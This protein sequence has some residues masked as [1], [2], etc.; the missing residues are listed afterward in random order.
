MTPSDPSVPDE[1]PDPGAGWDRLAAG[2]QRDIGWPEDALTW[3]W[4]CPSEENLR[5]VCDDVAGA[6]TLVVGCGGGQD[7]VALA[8]YGPASLVGVDP[9]REQLRHARALLSERGLDAG[10]EVAR[11]EH[12]EGIADRSV[13]VAVSVQ[14]LNYVQD[15]EAAVAELRRV[16]RLDGVLAFSV[17]HPAEASTDDEPP[18]AWHTSWFTVARD[19][20]WDGMSDEPIAFRSWFHAPSAWFTALTDGGFEVER[21]LEPA[22]VEDPRWIDRGWLDDASYA[23]LDLVPATILVRARRR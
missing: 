18:Y 8:A 22:P 16:L 7:L 14:A 17:M 10:L 3:G 4:R 5:L 19:W 2:Y 21:L 23:K 12:L 6:D 11:A 15:L 9:S 13:D 1:R 20:E